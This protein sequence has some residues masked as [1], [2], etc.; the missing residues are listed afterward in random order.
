MRRFALL[1]ALGAL[2]STTALAA[3]PP[4]RKVDLLKTFGS[5]LTKVT[6][7]TTVPVLLPRMLPLGGTYRLYASGTATRGS[8]LLSVEAAPDCR[9][10]NACFV[11]TFEGRRGGRLPGRPNV[12]L[13]VGDPAIFRLFGC[14]GSCSPNS[15]WFTHGGVL[16]S[17]QMKDLPKG[18]RAILIRM[19]NEAIAAGP[20]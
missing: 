6:H 4:A 1:L 17:W 20:R 5:R 10:A 3:A 19:A 14:G 13:A 18:E 16:Y 15:F 2:G 9:G 8:Y 12:R 11:A 7:S